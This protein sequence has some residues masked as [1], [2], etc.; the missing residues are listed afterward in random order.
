MHYAKSSTTCTMQLPRKDLVRFAQ[1]KA[2]HTSGQISNPVE[3][4]ITPSKPPLCLSNA[5]S[6]S[7]VQVTSSSTTRSAQ[8]KPEYTVLP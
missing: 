5:G 8:C 6:E 7:I 3:K 1:E 4:S 2:L